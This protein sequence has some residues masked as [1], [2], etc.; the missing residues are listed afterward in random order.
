MKTCCFTGHRVIPAA[1]RADIEK[2]TARAVNQLIADGV[3]TFVSGGAIGFDLLA[4]QV[5]LRA[6][7]VYPA[8]RLN[9]VLP[10]RD[11]DARWSAADRAAYAAILARADEVVYTADTYHRGCMHVRNRAMV[12][13]SDACI[14]YLTAATGGT[15]YTVN[16]AREKGIPVFNVARTTKTPI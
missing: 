11:Q 5:V 6:K 7:T 14:C 16:R 12:D 1:D 3:D 9:M 13:R 2:Q 8:V 4:A 10:C 15:A